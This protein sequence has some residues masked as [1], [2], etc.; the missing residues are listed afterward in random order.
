MRFLIFLL[1]QKLGEDVFTLFAFDERI[2]VSLGELI[3]ST[4]SCDASKDDVYELDVEAG[5]QERGQHFS[6]DSTLWLKDYDSEAF[7]GPL[8][9]EEAVERVIRSD[10]CHQ[11]TSQEHGTK[12]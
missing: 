2:Q 1:L 10:V 3:R 4:E 5:G 11:Y 12:R 9:Q 7:I 8:L 6:L